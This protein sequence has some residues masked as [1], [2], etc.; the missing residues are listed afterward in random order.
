MIARRAFVMGLASSYLLADSMRGISLGCQTNAWPVDP[1]RFDTLLTVMGKIREL[2]FAGFETGFRNLESQAENIEA[3]RQKIASSGL[4]FFGVHIFLSQ[5]DEATHI[6]PA[7]LY[8]KV[9]QTGGALGAQRLILSGAP[10]S[11]G[12]ELARKVAGLHQA[13]VSAKKRGMKLAYHNH[14]KEFSNSAWEFQGLL[15]LTDPSEVGF[16]LDAG[17]AFQGGA[18]VPAF[19]EENHRRISGLHLRDFRDGRQ[20]PL[21]S[22][23]FPLAQVA[24]VLKKTGWRGWVL[25]EEEREDGSKPGEHAVA[26]AIAA[27]R[28]QFG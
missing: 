1:A 12:D 15:R 16:L 2:G 26:P 21:G 5:Y 19:L 27:L 13:A 20:V 4:Q 24:V 23:D 9:C 18:D 8:E 7:E 28:E 17:H 11:S 14:N 6:A 10:V 3:A 22:G 25:A